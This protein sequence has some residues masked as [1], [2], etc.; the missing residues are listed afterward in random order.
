[1]LDYVASFV[2][3]D[4][5]H[6]VTLDGAREEHQEA[7]DQQEQVLEEYERQRASIAEQIQTLDVQIQEIYSRWKQD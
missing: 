5:L 4:D 1:M 2:E 7:L 6:V 3:E